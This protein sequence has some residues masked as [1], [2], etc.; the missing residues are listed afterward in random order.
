VASIRRVRVH[1]SSSIS[2][3][4]MQFRHAPA[5]AR[6]QRVSLKPQQVP[7]LDLIDLTPARVLQRGRRAGEA[8]NVPSD[9]AGARLQRANS[10]A[11]ALE[12]GPSC[13]SRRRIHNE[14]RARRAAR[15]VHVAEGARVAREEIF[16]RLPVSKR[17]G[18]SR[19]RASGVERELER[20]S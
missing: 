7:R 5:L 13:R 2:P 15:S 12:R 3:A 6:N 20:S 16:V 8:G 9:T 1:L 14:G 19:V 18:A 10:S 11:T 4:R 17:S